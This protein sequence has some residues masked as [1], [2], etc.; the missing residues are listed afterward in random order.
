MYKLQNNRSP[1]FMK[2]IFQEEFP[3]ILL[4][5]K[6]YGNL[7]IIEQFI[8]ERSCSTI[9]VQKHGNWSRLI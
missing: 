7:E 9:E 4:G 8:G 5:Q 2:E 6:K 3:H 1:K